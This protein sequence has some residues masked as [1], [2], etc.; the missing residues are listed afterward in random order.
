MLA[1][2]SGAKVFVLTVAFEFAVFA[3]GGK[4]KASAA[5]IA[6]TERQA[7][8][9]L[10]GIKAHRDCSLLNLLQPIHSRVFKFVIQIDSHPCRTPTLRTGPESME[11]IKTLE[12]SWAEKLQG[13]KIQGP[14]TTPNRPDAGPPRT[15]QASL[16]IHL[17]E[18]IR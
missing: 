3:F 6:V 12:I 18:S 8:G 15:G 5:S 4:T 13:T 10:D 9:L 16:E 14:C 2:G 11:Q 1:V 17:K 7:L